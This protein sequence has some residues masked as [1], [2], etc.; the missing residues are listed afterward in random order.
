ME[1]AMERSLMMRGQ[2]LGVSLEKWMI[3]ARVHNGPIRTYEF[4]F[5]V[6]PINTVL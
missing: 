6:K 1:E 3:R 5:V 2:T 4:W